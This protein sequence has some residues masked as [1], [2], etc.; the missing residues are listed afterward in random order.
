MMNARSALFLLAPFALLLILVC[1]DGTN[2][3]ATELR[4]DVRV[5]DP[6]LIKQGKTYYVFSTGS[7]NGS[8]NQGNIQI[9]A[10]D[11]LIKWRF[12]GTVFNETPAWITSAL[13]SMPKS[14]WAPDISYFNGKY[15]LYYSA[16][17]FGKNTSLIALV[18]NRTLNPASPDY[19]WIDEGEV[20]RS[21]TTDNW[22]AIDPHLSFDAEGAAWLSLGSFWSG[23]KLRRI[24][25][26]TG[27]LSAVDTTLYSL[28]AR[29]TPQGGGA[30]EAPAIAYHQ[31]YYYLFV[32]FDFCCRGIKSDY[33]IVVGRAKRITGPYLDKSGKRM[34]QGGGDVVL[35]GANHQVAPGGQSVYRDGKTDRLVYHYYDARDGGKSKLQLAKL[36]WTDDGWLTVAR[37]SNN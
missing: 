32:S 4:G 36:Q 17:F 30:I 29:P 20:T 1:G 13:G 18:T 26:R 3:T 2:L 5:H 37:T 12:L 8:I 22:N 24:D 28:A 9:R 14:L 27:K 11:D 23:I 16:S 6:S 35:T 19:K 34:D 7:P 33:K 21:N 10:S 25:A 15:H 31:G